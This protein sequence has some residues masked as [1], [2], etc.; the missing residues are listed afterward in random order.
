MWFHTEPVS[1]YITTMPPSVWLPPSCLRRCAMAGVGHLS[2]LKVNQ[3]KDTWFDLRW[4]SRIGIFRSG[5]TCEIESLTPSVIANEDRF[6]LKY[7][8]ISQNGRGGTYVL[9][10]C[11][12]YG[13][14]SSGGWPRWKTELGN[15]LNCHQA[16]CKSVT[17]RRDLLLRNNPPREKLFLETAPS[18][19]A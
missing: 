18:R 11:P 7:S 15:L 1:L 17:C 13:A 3:L 6:V 10:S 12:C 2:W 8:T 9:F 16:L 4:I 19:H 14:S 5:T